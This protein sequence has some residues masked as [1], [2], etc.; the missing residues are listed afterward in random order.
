MTDTGEPI[1]PYNVAIDEMV[2][3]YEQ[4]YTA[5]INDVLQELELHEQWAGPEIKCRTKSIGSQVVAGFAFTVQWVF[6]P[7]P[8]ERDQPAARMVADYPKD[9]IVVVDAGADQTSGFWGELAT[10]SCIASGVR[11]AVIN[12]GAKDTGFVASV[13]FPIFCRFTSPVDGFYRSRL[14]GWNIPIWIGRTVV[15]P[16]DFIVADSDGVLVIP[17]D[18]AEKVLLEAE[19]RASEENETRRLLKDGVRADEASRRTGRRDL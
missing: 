14:R 4:L 3:R 8:D 9:S 11:G 1:N 12:G 5:A 13:E 16:Y 15:H 7:R 19:R 17:H 18:V 6:D 2:A 10:T